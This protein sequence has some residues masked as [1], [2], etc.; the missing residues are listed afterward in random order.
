MCNIVLYEKGEIDIYMNTKS[1][2]WTLS[3]LFT[4]VAFLQRELLQVLNLILLNQVT[5]YQKSLKKKHIS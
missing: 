4:A 2:K 1:M 5:L 3:G